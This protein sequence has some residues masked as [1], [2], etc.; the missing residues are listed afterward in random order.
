MV[1]RPVSAPFPNR[2]SLGCR[3]LIGSWVGMGLLGAIAPL[4][5]LAIPGNPPSAEIG[6]ANAALPPVAQGQTLIINGSQVSIPW[7]IAHGQ[8]GLADYGVTDHLGATLLSN[9]HPNQ[10]PV[11]WFTQPGEAV[12][13]AAWVQGGYRFLDITPL[14]ERYGWQV[15]TQG[16]A[17][18][19]TT[20]PAQVVGLRRT[21]IPGG[22]RLIVDLSGPA[23]VA[24][25]DSVDAL[26]L[27][28]GAAANTAV[29]RDAIAAPAGAHLGSL[30]ATPV[31]TGI[32]L[33]ARAS[34]QPRLAT[35]A[36]PPKILIDIRAD[37]LQPHSIAWAPGV[38]WQQRY[39][40]VAGQSFPVYWLQLDPAQASLRPIWPDPTTAVGTAPLTTTAQRWQAIAAINAGFFNRNN[41]FP[42]G[43]VRANQNWISG[44]ILSRG[45]IGWNDQGQVRMERLFLR[46]ALTTGNGQTFPI[47]AINSGY[48]QAGIG[49]YT[50]A[51]GRTYQP[52][53]DGETVVTVING[54]VTAQQATGA[55]GS[56]SIAI[57]PEGYVLALRAYATA[58]QALPPG[59]PVT[60]ESELLPA[61]LAPFPNI[62][63]G[64]P[65]L[66]RDR[67]LVLDARL[68]QFS[69]AFG[70]QAA[71][72]SAI[73]LT[74]SGE[75]L[76]VAVHNSPLGPG[77]T[78]DQL[79]QIMI[80]LG[81]TD[82]LN[83]DGGSSASLYLGG[84]LINR[85]PRTAAR[86][87][88][89]IGVF[90]P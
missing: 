55:I 42:L 73:G 15:Q 11:Q 57:P 60:L 63:G 47:Q 40:A 46:Q 34:H 59:Q 75:I 32:R 74:A 2:F 25:A 30:T 28:L 38:R 70:T 14:A 58:A 8:I 26:T 72:R 9:G 71:P 52:I 6:L 82:A 4:P 77:P 62:V 69:A 87:N 36:N 65:L 78:L 20:P 86:V 21:A 3:W 68:E 33:Q 48:V 18:Q 39:V 67:T 45:V 13:L 53:L 64:G 12:D 24:L 51:W 44:P 22:E 5:A 29:L 83:L 90:L 10:Q 56:S 19:I 31:A 35:Q 16:T 43:A 66:I 76:L 81:S 61:S 49:L 37:R 1:R 41:Q 88:N 89:A 50:S 84:R 27:T 80:Q 17:L 85:S 79:A 54:V 23:P 7:M